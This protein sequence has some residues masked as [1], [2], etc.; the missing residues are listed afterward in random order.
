MG[1]SKKCLIHY[2]QRQS[3]RRIVLLGGLATSI[4]IHTAILGIASSLVP[5]EKREFSIA[6]V[7]LFRH[8]AVDV[9]VDSNASIANVDQG[10]HQTPTAKYDHP[11][12][13]IPRESIDDEEQISTRVVEKHSNPTPPLPPVTDSKKSDDPQT[14]QSRDNRNVSSAKALPSVARSSAPERDSI[15]RSTSS[16]GSQPSSSI[17]KG[18][19][20]NSQIATRSSV[21]QVVCVVCV[22]PEYPTSALASGIEGRPV[23]MVSI[24]SNGRVD[25]VSIR[26]SSGN[27]AIDQAALSAARRSRFKPVAGGAKIPIQYDLT[28]KGSQRNKESSRQGERKSLNLR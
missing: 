18:T 11:D 10:D 3:R 9:L 5:D 16:S 1:L 8:D 25:G 15:H 21:R 2:S 6:G 22:K 19:K 13:I 23:V 24:A 4:L 28:I 27:G 7:E 17:K 14:H 26:R 20:S 12:P